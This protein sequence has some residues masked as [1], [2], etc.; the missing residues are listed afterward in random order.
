M[1]YNERLMKESLSGDDN[2]LDELKFYAGS[3]YYNNDG[4]K[5]LFASISLG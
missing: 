5:S 2:A 1:S 4:C 3:R